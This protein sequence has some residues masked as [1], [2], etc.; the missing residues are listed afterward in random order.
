MNVAVTL[1][2][3]KEIKTTFIVS[4][5]DHG[6]ALLT[7]EESC[8]RHHCHRLFRGV[9][10]VGVHLRQVYVYPRALPVPKLFPCLLSKYEAMTPSL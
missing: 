10:Q 3:D 2:N 4:F 8:S 6:E 9:H 5:P 7:G 1:Y